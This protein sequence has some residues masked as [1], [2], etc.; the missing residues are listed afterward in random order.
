MLSKRLLALVVPFALIAACSSDDNPDSVS[1]DSTEAP[2]DSTADTTEDT[3]PATD[4]ST[5]TPATLPETS[6]PT[7]DT[8][9]DT[10]Q[11]TSPDTT[12]TTPDT[13]PDEDAFQWEEFGEGVETGSLQVPIDYE[14]PS[15]GTFDLFVARH[16]ASDPDQRIGSLL[17]N[18]GGPGFGG[19]DF[20]IYADQIYSPTLLD[21]FDIVGWDPRGTGLSEPAIDCIDDYDRYN[22]ATDITPDDEAERQQIIDLATEFQ[23]LCVE[24]NE[25][26]VMYV[27]T[28]NSAR[29]MNEIRAALGE[30]KISYFGFSYGSELGATWATLF[31]DT[32]RAAVL[33]GAADPDADFLQSGLQQAQGFEHSIETFLAQCSEDSS[34]EFNNGGDAEG[35]FD[36]LMLALDDAPVPSQPDRPDVNRGVALTAVSQGMYS[37]TLWDTLE[38]ALADAQAG[39]GSGLLALYDRYYVR[40]PDGTYDNSL[41]AFQTISCMD[42]AERL[43]V[44]EDDATAAAFNAAAP[45]FGA[46]TT[47]SYF[48][49]FYPESIDP[50]VEIT[51]AGAGPILVVGTTGDPATPLSSTENMAKALEDGVLLVIEAD[52]HT[53]YG[54]NDCSFDTIDGYLVD[55]EVPESGFTCEA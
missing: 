43:T 35:A 46:G 26:F 37:E 41:E 48:C 23:T 30:E 1:S 38:V 22:A 4:E 24:N 19:S 40:H 10:T 8:T 55:L 54:V 36:E 31:P 34:C 50:R 16:L 20:A 33:D 28:N 2:T 7:A 21:H 18:P 11:D 42:T 12:D 32:V 6:S 5:T 9:P 3:T 49:S 51:G 25:D 14:D 29:D 47:G 44:E 15:K 52:Q 27:G 13:V 39:D 17:V 53:G 45:R